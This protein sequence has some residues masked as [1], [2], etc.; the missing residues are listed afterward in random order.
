MGMDF[1]I[2]GTAVC[3]GMP[4]RPPTRKAAEH[5]V[6]PEMAGV[7][8]D[9]PR[10]RER[11][12]PTFSSDTQLTIIATTSAPRDSRARFMYRILPEGASAAARPGAWPRCP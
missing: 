3:S 7:D 8:A 12:P 9:E 1:T 6:Q 4:A 5:V 11:Q 10:E 2:E